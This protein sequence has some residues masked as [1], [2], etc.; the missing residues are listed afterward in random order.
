M[1]TI[2]REIDQAHTMQLLM[3]KDGLGITGQT[4]TVEIRRLSDGLYLDHDAVTTPYWVSSGGTKEKALT[5][6]TDTDGLYY[7]VFDPTAVNS[8]GKDQY[9]F[10]VRNTGTYALEDIEHIIY[11]RIPTDSVDLMLDM[12]AYL[13]KI[14]RN[15][16]KIDKTANTL[17]Y[18][19]DDQTTPLRVFDLF[20]NN[21]VPN[22]KNILERVPV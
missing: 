22:W 13:Y 1:Q 14:N 19:D 8:S 2:I 3:T 12:L 11:E 4:P 15:R 16:L 7:I 6:S 5:E 10:I 18:Y 20:D 9:N 17:T 21:G